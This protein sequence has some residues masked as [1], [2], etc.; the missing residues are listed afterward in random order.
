[1]ET[2]ESLV[3]A[4]GGD[5]T[6]VRRGSGL[7]ELGSTETLT[8]AQFAEML[9][10]GVRFMN[11]REPHSLQLLRHIPLTA[12]GMISVAAMTAE[13]LGAAMDVALRYFPLILPTHELH[14]VTVGNYIQV[15]IQRLH[16]LGQPYDELLTEIVPSDLFQMIKFAGKNG[17]EARDLNFGKAIYFSHSS[18]FGSDVYEHHFNAKVTFDCPESYFVVPRNILTIPLFT[19]NRNTHEMAVSALDGRLAEACQKQ[20][21]SRQVRRFINVS[22]LHRQVPD[23]AMVAEALAMSPRTLT[24]RLSDEGSSFGT[25]LESVRVEKAEGLLLG[26]KRPLAHIAEQLGYSD[27]SSFSRAF[28]RVKGVSPSKFRSEWMA[29]EAPTL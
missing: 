4:G 19:R 23:A 2:F 5:S 8:K 15:H 16:S 17:V 20:P 10:L 22:M 12:H 13:T 24:R 3:R 7:P 9:R 1:M 18:D 14:K 11:N 29:F 27:L 26:S 28:K 25:L 6:E 21:V